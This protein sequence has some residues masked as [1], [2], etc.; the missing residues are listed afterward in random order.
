[1]GVSRIGDFGSW[2]PRPPLVVWL[3]LAILLLCGLL[4]DGF[5]ASG[6]LANVARQVVVLSLLAVG[7][8][9]VV[10]AGLLDLTVG[11]LVT[12]VGVV[13]A[14]WM[15]GSATRA[16][17]G[18]VL[19]IAVG[20]G[21]G[22]I[23][24]L[25]DRWLRIDSL[26]L[27]IGLMTVLYGMVFMVADQSVGAPAPQI[28]LLANGEFAGVPLSLVLLAVITALAHVLLHHTRFGL[29]LQAIGSSEEGA[30]HAGVRIAPVC[31]AAFVLSGALAGVAGL[32]LLGRLGTGYPNAGTGMELD[33]V[34]A[35]VLGGTLLAGG[36]ASVVGSVAAAAV[37]GVISNVLNLL[38]VSS[39]VQMLVKGL[40]VVSVVVLQRPPRERLA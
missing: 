4:V 8:T 15:D 7:Q 34:V 11:A 5:A 14:L 22:M 19:A 39:F 13:A 35:V 36:R 17:S 6:N 21:V 31:V 23:T 40:I 26:V 10:A 2:V 12:L 1:M 27:T 9:F 30:S 33:A 20:A 25:L 18:T 3:L 37:L 38:E 29:Y 16:L 24:G 32:L 28:A